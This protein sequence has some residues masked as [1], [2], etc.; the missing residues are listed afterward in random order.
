MAA[1]GYD[2]YECQDWITANGYP[3]FDDSILINN[4]KSKKSY[5][6][7]LFDP[8]SPEKANAQ[9]QAVAAA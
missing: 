2:L 4:L 6:N 3:Y 8:E 7:P 1:K 9:R 5:K